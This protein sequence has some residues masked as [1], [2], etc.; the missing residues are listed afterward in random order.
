LSKSLW[1]RPAGDNSSEALTFY[2]R[3]GAQ[4]AAW[5]DELDDSNCKWRY[6]ATVTDLDIDAKAVLIGEHEVVFFERC[7]LATGSTPRRMRVMTPDGPHFDGDEHVA[8]D[9]R[10]SNVTTFRTVDDFRR[11]QT[12][13]KEAKHIAIV[14][15]GL[16]ASELA[17][18][19]RTARGD[20]LRVTM[21]FRERDVMAKY[22]PL[23]VAE[24]ATAELRR[25]GVD[26]RANTAVRMIDRSLADTPL[27][28][29][30]ID[31]NNVDQ[32]IEPDHVVLAIG[33]SFCDEIGTMF[34]FY[35]L[36]AGL[37]D[38]F[39]VRRPIRKSPKWRVSRSIRRMAASLSTARCWPP[40][41]SMRQVSKF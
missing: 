33:A 30:A 4:Q 11:L 14:G 19:L 17:A 38:P 28:V 36:R 40:T 15:G 35:N 29:H 1:L 12:I 34:F 37:F 13:S 22:L 5:M 21:L 10:T 7:L 9:Q 23:E 18:G 26:V 27:V 20:A 24:R 3:A 2:N 39:Q 16:L 25:L 41:A 32:F 6:N 8:D 31:A